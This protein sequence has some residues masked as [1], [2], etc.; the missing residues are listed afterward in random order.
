M[1]LTWGKFTK[2]IPLDPAANVAT[3]DSAPGFSKFY[4]FCTQVGEANDDV[5]VAFPMVVS[6]HDESTSTDSEGGNQS[7]IQNHQELP[8]QSKVTKPDNASRITSFDIEGPRG[9]EAPQ[10]ILDEE[11]RQ[12]ENTAAEFLRIHQQLGHISPKRIQRLARLGM[13]PKRLAK[14]QI[15]ACTACIYG[16]AT[17]RPWR[18]KTSKSDQ[19]KP[20][21]KRPGK[22]V[23][24][25]TK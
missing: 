11:E 5:P 2:I 22:C 24:W 7:Q 17:K 18:S 1:I 10:V 21:P 15:P 12:T 13:L 3:F 19:Q 6:D 8:S 20:P 16:K 4:A 9:S 25:W 23:C 14:C